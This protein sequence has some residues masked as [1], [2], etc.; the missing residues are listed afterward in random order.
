MGTPIHTKLFIGHWEQAGSEL[1]CGEQARREGSELGVRGASLSLSEL[2]GALKLAPTCSGDIKM[3]TSISI[4][5]TCTQCFGSEGS[6]LGVWGGSLVIREVV[7]TP[8]LACRGDGNPNKYSLICTTPYLSSLHWEWG[9][10]A[11]N[12]GSGPWCKTFGSLISLQ[13]TPSSLPSLQLAPSLPPSPLPPRGGGHIPVH[14]KLFIGHWEWA[15][16]RC[17]L[18]QGASWCQVRV[19]WWNFH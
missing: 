7:G 15:G 6:D 10:Q 5:S 13:L 11:G 19:T 17:E 16:A 12:E 3:Y 4:G 2:V 14:T 1:E 9:D 18:E 8:K